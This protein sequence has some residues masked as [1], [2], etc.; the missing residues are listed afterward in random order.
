MYALIRVEIKEKISIESIEINFFLMSNFD[1][2][3]LYLSFLY[4]KNSGRLSII[5]NV[6]YV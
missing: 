4:L 5:S 2:F 6:M 3:I 1:F